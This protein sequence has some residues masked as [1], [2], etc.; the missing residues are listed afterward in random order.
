MAESEIPAAELENYKTYVGRSM[1]KTDTVGAHVPLRMAAILDREYVGPASPP[2]WQYGLFLTS[3]PT[4][5]LGVDGH[6]RRF[7]LAAVESQ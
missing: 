1:T 3:A 6:P 2:M 5:K 7:N 4:S